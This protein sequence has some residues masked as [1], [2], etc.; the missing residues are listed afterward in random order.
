MPSRSSAVRILG[1]M[2]G[3]SCDGLDAACVEFDSGGWRPLWSASAGY[4]RELRERALA[5]QKPGTRETTRFWLELD[6]DLGRWYAGTIAR[7]LRGRKPRE[8]PVAIANHGQTLAHFPD[9]GVTLQLGD[10][11]RLAAETGL[12]VISHFRHGDMA[13][14]GQGAPLA[15]LFHKL[16][17][18][19]L[20]G[21][22]GVAIHNLGGISNLTYIAP[23]G[24][25]LAFDTGPANVWIDAAA[26]AATRGRATMDKGGKL[27]LSAEPDE[28]AVSRALAHPF[29]SKR[30]PKSTGRDDFTVEGLLKLTRARDARLVATAT[31][32][33]IESVARAYERWILGARLPLQAIALAGGGARNPVLVEGIRA[34]L[35]DVHVGLLEDAGLDSQLIEAQAFAFFGFMSLLGR[36]LGGSWT[37]ARGFG[38]PGWITPGENWSELRRALARFS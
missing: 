27:A 12:T 4:P 33:T 2:T 28:R 5:A 30:P 31:A 6:R 16:L 10:P 36:P 19:G 38:P 29:F 20:S 22:D 7:A 15:P 17:A 1:V 8:R 25:L 26:A 9:S 32:I 3:T 24:Q 14:G 23:D 35:P 37:G 13:V 11:S 18:A 21:E 34:R